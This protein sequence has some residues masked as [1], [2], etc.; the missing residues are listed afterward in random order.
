VVRS[1]LY[2]AATDDD[3]RDV[4]HLPPRRCSLRQRRGNEYHPSNLLR[5]KNLWATSGSGSLPSAWVQ[6]GF[7]DV[8]CAEAVGFSHGQFGLVVETLDHAAGELLPG[9]EI[10]EPS[11][12]VCG[13]PPLH[14]PREQSG[15][16]C[17]QPQHGV[18]NPAARLGATRF[19]GRVGARQI[20]RLYV[21]GGAVSRKNAFRCSRPPVAPGS[22]GGP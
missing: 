20:G 7:R 19:T 3:V 8:E 4:V 17:G 2:S 6:R 18:T 9:T 10:V 22:P 5:Q 12:A 16:G 11:P 21:S 14:L 1:A 13:Y 15:C